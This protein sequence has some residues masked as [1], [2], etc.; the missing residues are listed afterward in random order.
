MTFKYEPSLLELTNLI[1]K[2]YLIK[3]MYVCMNNLT[4][5]FTIRLSLVMVQGKFY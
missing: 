4:Q 3:K 5:Y 1:W 2:S